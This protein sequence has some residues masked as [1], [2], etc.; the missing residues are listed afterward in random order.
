MSGSLET[1]C[2]KLNEYEIEGMFG[3]FSSIGAALVFVLSKAASKSLSNN[4]QDNQVKSILGPARRSGNKDSIPRC[5]VIAI[6]KTKPTERYEKRNVLFIHMLNCRAGTKI[7]LELGNCSA[8]FG[9][10]Y[11]KQQWYLAL[12]HSNCQ[13]PLV[14]K[15]APEHRHAY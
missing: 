7:S 2:N 14:D 10:E 11:G 1:R 6:L 15:Q 5:Y 9:I 12:D 4:L 3:D 13:L 8:W